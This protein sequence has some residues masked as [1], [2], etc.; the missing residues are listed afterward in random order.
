MI[1]VFSNDILAENTYLTNHT[2]HSYRRFPTS[3][4]FLTSTG[5][6]N[7]FYEAENNKLKRRDN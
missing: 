4:I 7:I 6:V 2:N 3:S 1:E 5:F